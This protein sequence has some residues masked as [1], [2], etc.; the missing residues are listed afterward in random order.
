M[1]IVTEKV[2]ELIRTLPRFGFPVPISSIPPS[3]I[4]L[5]FEQGEAFELGNTQF[6]RIT[7]VGT[8]NADDRLPK[9]LKQHYGNLR[10]LGGNKNASAFRRHLGGALLCRSNPCDPR[11]DEWLRHGG[12]R[13]VDVEVLVSQTLR[14]DFT[15][16]CIP[17]ATKD[18]RRELEA[19]LIGLLSQRP[20]GM[21][22]ARWLGNHAR[23]PEV[24]KSGLWNVHATRSTPLT[25]NQFGRLKWLATQSK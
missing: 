4:Y 6:D 17:V 24:R 9:R 22:T 15:F 21:P 3:G 12:K 7:R 25:L 18:E 5:F 8:H 20:I 23:A 19:G 13:P 16:T 14:E 1:T 11:I 2:Y 10:S